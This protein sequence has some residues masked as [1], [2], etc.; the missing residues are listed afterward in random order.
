MGGFGGSGSFA[1]QTRPASPS[2]A[3]STGI[4]RPLMRKRSGLPII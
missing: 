1:I 4:R 3:E 2:T